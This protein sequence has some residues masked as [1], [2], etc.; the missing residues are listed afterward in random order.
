MTYL[1]D[2]LSYFGVQQVHERYEYF[3]GQPPQGQCR[4]SFS[5]PKKRG[6]GFVQI[7][8][9]GVKVP[10]HQRVVAQKYA[11]MAC[12]TKLASIGY[13]CALYPPC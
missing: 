12:V 10:Q 2:T 3:N 7:S 11:I 4:I 9:V 13:P 8:E 1:K 5:M 6:R